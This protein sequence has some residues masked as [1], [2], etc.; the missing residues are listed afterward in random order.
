VDGRGGAKKAWPASESGHDRA[1][2][3]R[4]WPTASVTSIRLARKVSGDKL[5]DSSGSPHLS[6]LKRLEAFRAA[7]GSYAKCVGTAAALRQ[8]WYRLPPTIQQRA[9]AIA[10]EHGFEEWFEALV[11]QVLEPE[12]TGSP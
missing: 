5:P 7:A 2:T 6:D 9:M 1:A 12:Q 11:G 3:D 8:A 4:S 10:Q